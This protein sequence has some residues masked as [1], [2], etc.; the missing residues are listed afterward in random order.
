MQQAIAVDISVPRLKIEFL[1]IWYH[2]VAKSRTLAVLKAHV[3]H[4]IEF[5]LSESSST[6]TAANIFGRGVSLKYLLSVF[7]ELDSMQILDRAAPKDHILMCLE[8]L[9]A[10]KHVNDSKYTKLVWFVQAMA[11][12]FVDEELIMPLADVDVDVDSAGFSRRADVLRWNNALSLI[13]I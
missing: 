10:I 11:G 1:R 9:Q 4:E 8:E 13:H 3:L 2:T 5:E 12:E 6:A 7:D